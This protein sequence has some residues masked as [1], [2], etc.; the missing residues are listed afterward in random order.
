MRQI[1]PF[2]SAQYTYCASTATPIGSVAF[3]SVKGGEVALQPLSG[4]RE[5]VAVATVLPFREK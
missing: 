1:P 2:W 3:A 4:Q 5:M